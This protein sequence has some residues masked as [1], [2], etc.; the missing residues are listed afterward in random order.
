VPHAF[1]FQQ[2]DDRSAARPLVHDWR[3][4]CASRRAAHGGGHRIPAGPP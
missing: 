4:L 3:L 1:R 2:L